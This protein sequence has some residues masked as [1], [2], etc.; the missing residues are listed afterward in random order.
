M[1]FA[2]DSQAQLW[3][4]YLLLG[5]RWLLAGWFWALAT[6]AR[7]G[8]APFSRRL[9]RALT[10]GLLV[11]L[12][13]ALLLAAGRVWSPA[14]DWLVWAGLTLGAAGW[15]R[16]R[17]FALCAQARPLGAGLLAVSLSGLIVVLL[18]A[19]SEWLAGG[20][21]PGLYQNNALVIARTH[22]LTPRADSIYAELT[23]AERDLFLRGDAPYHEAFPGVP[24]RLADGAMPLRFF[25]LTPLCGALF[26]RLGG[27]E[28]L[29]RL[30]A[31]LSI[32]AL[33]P[34][35]ALFSQL[36]LSPRRQAL[37]LLPWLGSAFWWY[38][39]A[40]PTAE[41][42]YL[43]LLVGGLSLYLQAYRDRIR[44]PMGAALTLFAAAANHLNAVVLL[45]LAL[46]ATAAIEAAKAAPGRRTRLTCCYGALALGL[47]WNLLFARTSVMHLEEKDHALRII[48]GALALCVAVSWGLLRLRPAPAGVRRVQRGAA[49]LGGAA[50]ILLAG[51]ALG[52]IYDPVRA[53]IFLLADALPLA[54]PVLERLARLFPFQ[55]LG[56][57]LWAATGLAALSCDHRPAYQAW[58]VLTCI[59]GGVLLALLILPGIAPLYPWALRR[60]H[61]FW[62]PFLALTQ[63]YAILRV[64]TPR[65]GWSGWRR[66]AL[67]LIVLAGL[68]DG[69]RL[70]RQA[71]CVSDY[72]GLGAVVATLDQAIQPGDVIVADDPRWGTPLLMA[73]GR[74]VLNG[75]FL[76]RSRD[77]AYQAAYLETLRRLR[78]AGNRRILWLTS[79]DDGLA[80]YP[81]GLDPAAPAL[82]ECQY[83]YVTIAHG[84]RARSYTVTSHARPLRIYE[85]NGAFDVPPLI[86]P[87]AAP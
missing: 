36:G 16:R 50:G 67:A 82:L 9:G 69:L 2:A 21:D 66:A 30:P 40:V 56:S 1:F 13:P 78:R 47:A 74:D 48:L 55:G 87:P 28:L 37:G 59:L 17:G 64:L 52:L 73:R 8:D 29:Y 42:L 7:T 44:W 20:W 70:S 38:H 10:V 32:W 23:P 31:I 62:L 25:H 77:P 75:R 63:T 41:P 34:L 72:R 76:W 60:Y 14:A 26:H 83:N 65:A 22:G 49:W 54:G 27:R 57:A 53:R 43:L 19:R 12:L 5:L 84:V 18:P 80:I 85:W 11:N 71:A 81:V 15:A 6:G 45:G 4:G 24:V 58:R 39:Q 46:A 35:L 68:G 3:A 79:T 51:L 61:A 33:F 86:P